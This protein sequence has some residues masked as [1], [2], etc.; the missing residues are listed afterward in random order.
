MQGTIAHVQPKLFSM[1][2]FLFV[3]LHRLSFQPRFFFTSLLQLS[4]VQVLQL[5]SF[6]QPGVSL[7]PLIFFLI[8]PIDVLPLHG[9]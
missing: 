9:S 1:L 6:L 3:V 2:E 4:Y 8:Q 5:F 7:L